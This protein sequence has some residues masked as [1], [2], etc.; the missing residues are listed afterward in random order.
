MLFQRKFLDIRS[1]ITNC[2][3]LYEANKSVQ[4]LSVQLKALQKVPG[5]WA[6]IHILLGNVLS[7]LQSHRKL[8]SLMGFQNGPN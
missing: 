5:T 2:Q 3:Q 7:T 1:C 8:P 6:F 4:G